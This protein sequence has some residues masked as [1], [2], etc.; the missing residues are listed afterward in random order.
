MSWLEVLIEGISD[1]PVVREILTRRF[2]LTEGLDFTV[3]WH[4]GKG[5]LPADP[6]ALA[7]PR[8]TA[9]LDQLP[10]KLIAYGKRTRQMPVVLVLVDVDTTPCHEL[11]ASLNAMLRAL[12]FKPVVV[13]RLAIEEIESWFVSDVNALRAAYPTKVKAG[14][15]RDYQPDSI[16]NTWELL[17]SALGSDKSLVGAGVKTDWAQKISPHLNLDNPRSPSLR[18]FIEGVE[19]LVQNRPVI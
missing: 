14:K 15:L 19:R 3:S 4:T 2:N 5:T 17:A 16:V 18:K 6:L 13:F 7:D 10:S 1:A 9:L 12:P 11:L 8:K